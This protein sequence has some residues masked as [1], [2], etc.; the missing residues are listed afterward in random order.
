MAT[1]IITGT[2]ISGSLTGTG[3]FDKIQVKNSVGQA[4]NITQNA[5]DVALY[6]IVIED[7]SSTGNANRVQVVGDVMELIAANSKR[8][9]LSSGA[10]VFNQDSDDVNFRFETNNDNHALFI[11]GGKDS[12]SIGSNAADNN[13]H[14]KLTV[15]GNVGITGSLHVSGNIST[16]GSIIAKEFRT[17]FVNQVVTQASG[18]T[19]FGDSVDD[20]H[21]FTGS[22]FEFTGS[23][24]RVVDNALLGIGSSTNLNLSHN[25]TNGVISEGTGNL[26]IRTLAN[27]KDVIFQSDDGSGGVTSYFYLDG[28]V[29]KT[30]F[31]QSTQ[32]ADNAKATFGAAGDMEIYHDGTN[33]V[34]NNTTGHL[35]IYNNV[36][37]ADIVLLS[38][39]GSG[40]TTAYFTADGSDVRNIL[41]EDTHLLASKKLAVGNSTPSYSLSI[42][43]PTTAYALGDAPGAHLESATDHRVLFKVKNT[44][45]NTGASAPRAGFDLE[46]QNHKNDTVLRTILD[47]KQMTAAGGGGETSLTVPQHFSVLV[48]NSASL[49]ET[50]GALE[51][52]STPG[53]T[54]AFRVGLTGDIAINATNKLYLDGVNTSGN[55]YIS[56]RASDI[57]V[58]FA[59]G[60]NLL[61]LSSAGSDPRVS[62]FN[63][64]NRDRDF[65]FCGDTND[66][67]LYFDASAERVGIGTT[68][69]GAKLEVIGDISGSLTSTGSFGALV[70]DPLH[71]GFTIG[72]HNNKARIIYNAGY[73]QFTDAD[74]SYGGIAAESGSFYGDVGIR[75]TKKL[76]FDDGEPPVSGHTYISETAGDRLDFYVGGDHMFR[77]DEGNNAVMIPQDAGA[78]TFQIGAG[79][80]LELYVES[81]GGDTAII[82]SKNGDFKIMAQ[83]TDADM[84]FF[85]DDGSGGDDEYLRL[86]GG[87]TS[88]DMFVDTRLAATKKLYFDGGGNSYIHEAS[89]DTVEIYVGGV[90]MLQLS[91]ASTDYVATGDNTLLGV[92]DDVDFFIKHDGTNTKIGN[93]TGDLHIS[94]SAQDKDVIFT[95]NDGGT[96]NTALTIDGSST[97][98]N[99]HNRNING[100]NALVFQ[101]TGAGEGVSW[102]G[103]TWSIFISPNDMSNA[104]G[105]LQF[106]SGSSGAGNVNGHIAMRG[107]SEA[108][109]ETG[110]S[111]K[112]QLYMPSSSLEIG[113]ASAAGANVANAAR[114]NIVSEGNE[115]T[116]QLT[117]NN[118][119]T[120]GSYT[121]TMMFKGYEGRGMGTFYTDV[122]YSGHEFFCGVPY[123]GNAQRFQIGYDDG[124][125]AEYQQSASIS[126]DGAN[127]EVQVGSATTRYVFEVFGDAQITDTSDNK[128]IQ[129]DATNSRLLLQDD[130]HLKLGTGGDLFAY[131]D[132]TDTLFRNN[133]GNLYI[134]QLADDK[135]IILRSDDG[136]G[137]VTAYITL[138]GSAKL[139]QI[140]EAMKF[141]DS[142]QLQIGSSADTLFYHDGSNTYLDNTGANNFIIQQSGDDQDLVFRCDDGSGGVASYITLDGSAGTVNVDKELHL[143]THLDMGDDDRIKLG[144]S[145]DLQIVHTSNINFIHSVSSNTDLYFRVNDGGTDR[146]A[147][148]I[149]SS[150]NAQTTIRK[151]I[152]DTG[153][154]NQIRFETLEDSG[155]IADTFSGNTEQSYIFFDDNTDS[156]DPGFIMHETRNEAETNEGVIHL[157][158]SDDNAD[159]DYISIHG[160][161]DADS[162][163]LSTSGK[164]EGVST[165]SVDDG[166]E[167]A[168]S[169]TNNGDNNTG[170]FFPAADNIGFSV[171]GGEVARIDGSGLGIGMT[172]A[173]VLDLKTASG[174][175][176]IR[177]DAP[178]GSDTEIK[179]FNAGSVVFTI[180]HDDGTGR[181]VIGTSNVDT[182]KVTFDTSGNVYATADVIA[183][184]S[185]KRLKENIRPIENAL[186]KIDKLSGFVYNWNEKANKEAGYDMNKDYVG[187]FAQDVEKV[188]PEAVDLAPFDNGKDNKSISGENYL[189]VQYEKLVPLLIESIKELKQEIKEL[190]EN[191][192]S[193]R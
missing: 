115:R 83:A 127:K 182:A 170:I 48:N 191:D 190:K 95:V 101:D 93:S 59:G 12:I 66:G 166:S 149:D 79:Q 167:G 9:E 161:N 134:D 13:N 159:G 85:C 192:T 125:L 10:I 17:E 107:H 148:I 105:N 142:T 11:D 62:L 100:V 164:I 186:D 15:A 29:T 82:R 132:G 158:P 53:G 87:A 67:V 84:R 140:D 96:I 92:G 94:Q 176:R 143:S 189:T 121:T 26:T 33:S 74:N 169:Y 129:L 54:E 2:S 41:H 165:I 126:I 120:N 172:P 46:V 90:R 14:E 104:N 3:S 147:I 160:T 56:E 72:N 8:V 69:P 114:A 24:L 112:T 162:L 86:D 55:T 187:V 42:V 119:G 50:S 77:M 7:N 133:T 27:D 76:Y 5:G 36:N 111:I 146:D 23:A 128:L 43:S 81:G 141:T 20:I 88:L 137:G 65:S 75:A 102:S 40:G 145:D 38:D 185:D 98:F 39:D 123:Q 152:V 117:A 28:S 63:K 151:L 99:F 110:Y 73:F 180:G 35:Q 44:N 193:S 64:D 116:L 47:L 91:E 78:A 118:Q 113:N 80:D 163:K 171:N 97:N 175:C 131:H 71:K 135:D 173:E 58:L 130:V 139:T 18:S 168:P 52:D 106:V 51:S 16:S 21:R 136:S 30:I 150:E 6:A 124:G 68:S 155:N 49:F 25:G 89:A 157:C 4:V 45:A 183:F 144:A 178:N 153:T 57:L 1:S 60:E 19:T 34:I 184:S 179:F 174:D 109:L 22:I 156:N 138:D 103:G 61:E 70:I 154:S 177:L 108:S 181:F 32:H 122:N 31:A 188:Q 37:D